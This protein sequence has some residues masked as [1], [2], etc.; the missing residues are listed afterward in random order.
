VAQRKPHTLAPRSSCP[1]SPWGNDASSPDPMRKPE[2]GSISRSFRSAH[3]SRSQW[4]SHLCVRPSTF[5]ASHLLTF[6]IFQTRTTRLALHV[7]NVDNAYLFR[8]DQ[9]EMRIRVV[10][11]DAKGEIFAAAAGG[12][13]R[14][15]SEGLVCRGRREGGGGLEGLKPVE[16]GQAM[17]ARGLARGPHAR[18]RARARRKETHPL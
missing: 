15:D 6:C 13:H 10:R 9:L 18:R 1:Q 12:H 7:A 2:H 4:A 3:C 17:L 5:F 11:A 14:R 16:E 8:R